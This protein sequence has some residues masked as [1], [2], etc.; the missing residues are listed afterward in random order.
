MIVEFGQLWNA[1]AVILA[2]QA[3]AWGWRINRE[4]GLAEKNEPTWLPVA[5][6]MNLFAMAVTAGGVFVG[7]VLGL[8]TEQTAG[9]YF[10]LAII[11]LVGH[12]TALA[13]HYELFRIGKRSAAYFPMQEKLAVAL[14]CI[15]VAI[16]SIA[17]ISS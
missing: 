12:A 8:W 7:P 4:S 9:K 3:T 1:A 5:D 10:G 14:T 16:Y 15:V 2:L 13:G 11:L 17:A 6:I